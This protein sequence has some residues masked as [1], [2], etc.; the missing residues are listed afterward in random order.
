MKSKDIHEFN[1]SG[2]GRANMNTPSN[3]VKDPII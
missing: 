1:R 3:A 2:T